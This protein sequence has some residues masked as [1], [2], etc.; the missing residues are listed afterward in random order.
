M[1][2]NK[3]IYYADDDIDDRDWVYGAS[4]ELQC[5]LE[6]EFFDNGREVLDSLKDKTA[7]VPALIVLDLN[8]PEMDGRQTLQKL[9]SDPQY[10]SIPV[11]ILSTSANIIDKE[12]CKMLGA[13]LFLVKPDKHIEW[14]NIVRQLE[15]LVN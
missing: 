11:A 8:M 4:L 14:Q 2:K 9:K 5:P 1:N 15:P 10:Q 12:V 7:P 3:I 13:S 6:F